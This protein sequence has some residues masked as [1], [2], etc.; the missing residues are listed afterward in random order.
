MIDYQQCKPSISK[1]S[2]HHVISKLISQPISVQNNAINLIIACQIVAYMNAVGDLLLYYG[3]TKMAGYYVILLC[4]HSK[5][6]HDHGISRYNIYIINLSF[7]ILA[8]PCTV[9]CSYIVLCVICSSHQNNHW[10]ETK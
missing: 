2:N 7:M 8:I 5:T 10:R 9:K 6:F 4:L 3:K 1:Q